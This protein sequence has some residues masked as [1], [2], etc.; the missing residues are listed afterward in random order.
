MKQVT[1]LLVL[2][3]NIASVTWA[4]TRTV[5]LSVPGMNC[6]FCPITIRKALEKVDGVNKA[7]VDF[8]S[9]SAVVVFDDQKTNV[10]QL[11][12]ATQ[13]AGY[14]SSEIRQEQ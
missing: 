5:K 9:K 1:W 12:N 3:S 11:T 4:D 10:D 7:D 13:N 6:G 14:P 2:M 8:E